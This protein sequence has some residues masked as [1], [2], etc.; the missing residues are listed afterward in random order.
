MVIIV[1]SNEEVANFKKTKEIEKQVQSQCLQK[2][3]NSLK[4]DACLNDN[5]SS[6]TKVS[7]NTATKEKLDSLPGIGASKAEDI[8]NYRNQN[9]PFKTIDELK[10]VSG[11]GESLFAKIK[12]NITV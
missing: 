7:I 9:G 4:N 5:V 10:N 12:E 1:Y 8:I 2:D 6:S 11:I 3:E